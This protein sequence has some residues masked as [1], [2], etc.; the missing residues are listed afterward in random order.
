MKSADDAGH[1]RAVLTRDDGAG[2]GLERGP[3]PEKMAAACDTDWREVLL[4]DLVAFGVVL[5]VV[6]EGL[7]LFSLLDGLAVGALWAAAIGIVCA[8]EWRWRRDRWW[9]TISAPLSRAAT[10]LVVG[11]LGLVLAL[12]L[13]AAF[14]PPNTSDSL[15]YHLSRVANWQQQHGVRH[16]A[17]GYL[18]QLYQPP[19]AEFAMLNLQVLAN[20]DRLANFVQWASMLAA[21]PMVSL[22]ARYLGANRDGQV[23]AAVFAATLPVGILE[24]SGTQNDYVAA[25]WLAC[26]VACTWRI[27]TSGPN[28]H[29]WRTYVT[30][31]AALGLALN[32]KGTNYFLGL[33]FVCTFGLLHLRRP[34]RGTLA[35]LALSGLIALAINAGYFTRNFELFGSVLGP[36]KDESY[37][38]TYT[39]DSITW[40][41]FASNVVRNIGLHLGTPDLDLNHTIYDDI[42]T[43][44][45]WLGIS[46][47]SPA[48]T[49]G[50]DRYDHSAVPFEMH[51]SRAGNVLAVL[52]LTLTLIAAVCS[53]S[54][55]GRAAVGAYAV[56]WLLS[57]GV[58][59]LL[60]KWQVW[61]AR[62][63]LGWFVLAAPIVGVVW[64][65][66]L[67]TWV[68]RGLAVAAL[69][70][71]LQRVLLL[72]E[73]SPRRMAL[74]VGS[75]AMLGVGLW[76]AA[77]KQV[78]PR[79]VTRL[80]D[81]G[82]HGIVRHAW[83]GIGLALWL[84]AWPWLAYN[85]VRPLLGDRSVLVVS[86]LDQYFVNA[87]ELEAPFM[88]AA[89]RV[90]QA[91]CD[92]VG[93]LL[94]PGS[95]DYPMWVLLEDASPGVQI[96]NVDV[97]NVSARLAT[98]NF[99]PCAVVALRGV[100]SDRL[101]VDGHTF[102]RATGDG[103]L[104]SDRHSVAVF[105][106]AA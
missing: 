88:W 85:E 7:S 40:N 67:S 53:G 83:L 62:L 58:F 87:P 15:A 76:L 4:E 12:A 57:F 16:Y 74:I 50:T 73:G 54:F 20:S 17:A 63:H 36:G 69:L 61:N 25:L 84:A 99:Q 14:A 89:G 79:A 5:V 3:D 1:F 35:R 30:A 96:Q 71:C 46:P 56:A 11:V 31:G 103:A 2:V 68:W 32:A 24:A 45:Q 42:V 18:P 37:N 93:L 95:W 44:H 34:N 26:F 39:V 29:T 47:A 66:R 82:R 13:V 77:R 22:I 106:P 64:T 92:R 8:A 10:L 98:P 65:Q 43:I 81:G 78:W 102:T 21:L 60:L 23:L 101:L 72:G 104:E 49:F 19:L 38:T 52:L 100:A 91:R 80:V 55:N 97:P 27:W 70:L 28:T 75:L 48:T 33:P 86:R 6:T 59:C 51:D 41:G 105:L 94:G 90:Q 9:W